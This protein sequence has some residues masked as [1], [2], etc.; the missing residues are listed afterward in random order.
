MTSPPWH[1]VYQQVQ[2]WIAAG[3]LEAMV[4]D[5]RTLLRLATGRAEQPS[6]AIFD[7]WTLKSTPESGQRAGYDGH[8]R[9]KGSKIHMAVD[10]FLM[11]KK[12]P[13]TGGKKE[14]LR[15]GSNLAETGCF[16]WD[17]MGVTGRRT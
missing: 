8:K 1:T 17:A 9:Q 15:F 5:L 2:R 12:D 16:P 6:A 14:T 4:Q 7:G 10:T 3:V 11:L 13:E